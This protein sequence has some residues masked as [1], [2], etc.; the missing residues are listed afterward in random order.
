MHSKQSGKVRRYGAGGRETKAY[1][2]LQA[3]A[4]YRKRQEKADRELARKEAERV[5]F[6]K[7]RL[8]AEFAPVDKKDAKR[9]QRL[10]QQQAKQAEKLAKQ[11]SKQ[12]GQE[13]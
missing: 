3:Y 1:R 13:E 5:A 7:E 2:G 11:L 4:Q 8:E 12:A 9:Q 6:Y 10:A